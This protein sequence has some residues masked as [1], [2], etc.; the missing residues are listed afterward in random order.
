M[1][2]NERPSHLQP[3]VLATEEPSLPAGVT[4]ILPVITQG[5]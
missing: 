4:T 5:L 2:G 1:A 3:V